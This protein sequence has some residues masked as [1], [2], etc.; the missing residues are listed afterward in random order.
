MR[1]MMTIAFLATTMLGCGKKDVKED[2]P[3]VDEKPPVP[4]EDLL[5]ASKCHGNRVP[6]TNYLQETAFVPA[7]SGASEEAGRL[8][9]AKLRDR[10]CQGYRC[11]ELAPMIT[12]WNTESDALQVCAMAV[13]KDS[14]VAEFKSAPRNQLDADLAE[15][16]AQLVRNV[17]AK[18]EAR[19]GFDN[20][21]DMGVDGGPRAEWLIDRMTAALS[22]HGALIA[23]VPADWSGLGVPDGVDAVLRAN[24]TP[25]HG[26]EAMLEVTWKIQ[27]P[28]GLKAVDAIAFPELIG[29][30][31]NPLSQLP[32]LAGVNPAISLRFDARPGGGLCEGQTTEL[33]LETSKALHVRVVNLFGDGS[34]GMVIYA[35][36]GKVSPQQTLSLGEFQVVKATDVPVERFLVLGSETEEGL[37]YFD[38]VSAPC[39]IPGGHATQLSANRGLPDGAK[40]FTTSRSYRILEGDECSSFTPPTLPADWFES[41]PLCY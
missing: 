7:G 41:L 28:R 18:G 32:A 16:A 39:R 21:T 34:Q 10:I 11:S 20:I 19:I 5:G 12:L 31:I 1:K 14:D 30:S 35:S 4:A 6:P 33:R 8:A 22:K 13:I 9:A 26:R 29:P 3:A 15:R 23:H 25:M 24:I 38:D 37:G 27:L 40:N 36:D 2:A 17:G